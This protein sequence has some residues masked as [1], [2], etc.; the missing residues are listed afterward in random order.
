MWLNFEGAFISL[1]LYLNL[2]C[3]AKA[4]RLQGHRFR[5]LTQLSGILLLSKSHGTNE[6]IGVR[7]KIFRRLLK[8]ATL[9]QAILATFGLD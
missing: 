5:E 8:D 7:A 9:F 6:F 4:S 2:S 1:Y 3:L